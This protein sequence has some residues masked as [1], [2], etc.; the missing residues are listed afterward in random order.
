MNQDDRS[1]VDRCAMRLV[2][3][4]DRDDYERARACIGDG[5]MN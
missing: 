1:A 5:A 2:H 3:Y 4:R